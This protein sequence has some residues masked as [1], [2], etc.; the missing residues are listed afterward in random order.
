MRNRIITLILSIFI[1][2]LMIIYLI[3]QKIPLERNFI[4]INANIQSLFVSD[5]DNIYI[6]KDEYLLKKYN[7]PKNTQKIINSIN[8]LT[9]NLNYINFDLILVPS[10]TN[11]N[12]NKLPFSAINYDENKTISEIYKG[13]YVNYIDVKN[14]IIETSKKYPMYYKTDLTITDY[15][16]YYLY[17]E[18]CLNNNIKEVDINSFYINETEKFYGDLALKTNYKKVKDTRYLFSHNPE[19]EIKG[20][21]SLEYL[22][23]EKTIITNKTLN[24][25]NELIIITDEYSKVI[26]QFLINH[27]KKIH[28]INPKYYQKSIIEYIKNNPNIKDGIIIYNMIELDFDIGIIGLY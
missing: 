21:K 12:Q 15:N 11:I 19:I 6:S 17:K 5:I 24:S 20:S 1:L 10:S 22:S 25:N 7:K 3:T 2:V 4:K 26:S 9:T 28:I 23:N 27:Y 18:Y 8:N 14:K 13:V 16:A